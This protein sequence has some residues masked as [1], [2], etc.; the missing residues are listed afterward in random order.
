[1]GRFGL[2]VAQVKVIKPFSP[3]PAKP[4]APT[5]TQIVS[6]FLQVVPRQFCV[7]VRLCL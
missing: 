1:M 4:L 6:F 2:C 5:H 7:A 3:H